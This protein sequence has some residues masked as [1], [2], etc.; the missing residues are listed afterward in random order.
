MVSLMTEVLEAHGGLRNWGE[1]SR[2]TA[3]LSLGGPFWAA[4]GW[5]E[6]YTSQTVTLDPHREHITFAPF[7]GPDRFSVLDVDPEL[8]SIQTTAGEILDQ[9]RLPRDTFPASFVDVSTPWDAIQVAYFTSAA[10]WNYLT[11]PF[12]FASPDVVTEE[13]TPWS[14]RGESWRRLAVQF[15]RTNANHNQNQV[16]YYD[17]AFMLRRMDYSPDVTGSPPVAHYTHDHRTFDGFVFPT[18]RRVHL[19][20]AAGNANQEFAPITMDVTMVTVERG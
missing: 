3:Q 9:R 1:V 19:H 15:P 20:D 8:V 6:V 12:V 17:S 5:P 4:R 13:L 2:L 10:V 11:A 14:E 18:R 16:F 7:T